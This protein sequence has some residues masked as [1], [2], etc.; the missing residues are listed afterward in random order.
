MYTSWWLVGINIFRFLKS[1]G[2]T[3]GPG[4]L[5]SKTSHFVLIFIKIHTPSLYPHHHLYSHHHHLPP[6]FPS[7]PYQRFLCQAEQRASAGLG[8]LSEKEIGQK[9]KVNTKEVN[10]RKWKSDFVRR[11]CYLRSDQQVD[12]RHRGAPQ[13]FLHQHLGQSLF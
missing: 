3:R 13:Q 11:R 2:C 9:M 8:H 6:P 12:A 5:T 7:W 10:I 1:L 4:N